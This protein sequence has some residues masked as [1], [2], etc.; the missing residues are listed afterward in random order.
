[1]CFTLESFPLNNFFRTLVRFLLK[2]YWLVL[3]VGLGLSALSYP[4]M[5]HLFKNISTDPID[6]L[7]KHYPTV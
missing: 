3:L 1:M 6:L 7:P 5:I 2:Y 4:R